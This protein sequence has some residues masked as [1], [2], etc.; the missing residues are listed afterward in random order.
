MMP[1]QSRVPLR[2][3]PLP[4]TL[5]DKQKRETGDDVEILERILTRHD[6]NRLKKAGDVGVLIAALDRKETGTRRDAVRALGELADAG[7]VE[8]LISALKDASL[9]VREASARAL[10]DLGDTRAVEP[11]IALLQE[12]WDIRGPHPSVWPRQQFEVRWAATEA[13]G[14]LG[15]PRAIDALGVAL[16]DD[17][18]AIQRAAVQALERIG[19]PAIEQLLARHRPIEPPVDRPPAPSSHQQ[20]AQS[21]LSAVTILFWLVWIVCHV[22]APAF[23]TSA[24]LVD[25]VLGSVQVL[26]VLAWIIVGLWGMEARQGPAVDGGPDANAT[27]RPGAPL[28]RE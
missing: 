16:Y 10:G 11:L 15:D 22:M 5:L 6:I 1:Q 14:K 21:V 18:M 4:S 12:K 28:E 24:K 25:G 7:A 13:L 17:S 23:G 2:L 27:V 3:D 9:F 19:G 8:P 26:G 20:K